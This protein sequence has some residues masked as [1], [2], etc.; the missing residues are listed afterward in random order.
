MAAPDA[1]GSMLDAALVYAARGW[2]V[3]P[4]HTIEGGACSCGESSCARAGKH[5]RTRNGLHNA[6]TEEAAIRRWWGTWS[7]ANIGIA[8]GSQS[9]FVVLDI[10]SGGEDRLVELQG[11]HGRL[12]EAPSQT[13]GSGGRHLLFAVPEG[14]LRNSNSKV[15]RKIDVRAD[16][17]YIVAPPSVHVS[18]T[19][20]AW[21]LAP[22]EAQLPAMPEWLLARARPEVR[23]VVN[24]SAPI[25]SDVTTRARR[26]LAAMPP[27]VSG[28]N[29]HGAL[30]D[31]ACA[32][33]RGF[34]LSAADAL[35]L[36]AGDYNPRC[37]PPWTRK[38]L[39]HKIADAERAS[40]RPFGY[41][42]DAPKP[43][44]AR[45]PRRAEGPA[46][47]P[48]PDEDTEREAIAAE[49]AV[50]LEV[51]ARVRIAA[52]E[53]TPPDE[54]P[55]IRL[56][57][58][59]HV[60]VNQAVAALSG[61]AGLYARDGVLVVVVHP[62]SEAP[63]VR[64]L[65]LATM[66]ERLT[67]AA[68]FERLREGEWD[69][70]LPPDAVALAALARGH[71]PGYRRLV[72]V[73]EAPSLRPDGSV[74]DVPGYDAA[75]GYLFAPTITFPRV[76][77]EPTPEEVRGALSALQEVFAD[78]PY[79]GRADA[80]AVLAA[81][82]TVLARP[83]IEGAVP[84][85]LFDATTPGSG[86]TLQADI[87]SLL[88]T[89]RT[90]AK[91]AYPVDNDDE[92][93]KILGGCALEGAQLVNFD[94]IAGAFGGAP[95]DKV[96]TADDMVKLRILGTSNTPAVRW[97]AVVM[98][99]GNNIAYRGDTHRRVLIPRLEPKTENPEERADFRYPDLRG[100]VRAERGRLVCAA[101]TILRAWVC[102]GRPRSGCKVWGSFEA[103]S[104]LIPPALVW[105]GAAD[106]MAC[107]PVADPDAR[108]EERVAMR[109]TLEAIE[110]LQGSI[111][112]TARGI[113]DLLYPAAFLRG[114]A[115]PDAFGDAREAIEMLTRTPA[116]RRPDTT[117]LG[118]ALRRWRRRPLAGRRLDMVGETRDKVARW[119]VCT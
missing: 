98:G 31:A 87:V 104:T 18:G 110:Q 86:K 94:N 67:A 79:R 43:E 80:A 107:R 70:C 57:A 14:G 88:A 35:A 30:W 52:V 6:T 117:R 1:H 11:V 8:T 24:T 114:E 45:A 62:P 16:G 112:I 72:G 84:A 58:E 17:G 74:F 55:R 15:A 4:L 99:T 102:A 73:L 115:P 82:F 65:A 42:R 49:P 25:P 7:T 118:F 53:A 66:R 85:F 29:G 23:P 106:P 50:G 10:D 105:A 56:G 92:V 54:R 96:L 3:F 77:A 60:N 2:A 90:T 21:T 95:I 28:Q 59:L 63:M 64:V 12:P 34:G 111:G 101:L 38:E 93:E 69:R 33:V 20:Y 46:E 32:M 103:W 78:F 81:V 41:L 75:T 89:G 40:D 48:A 61:D 5:P 116:G 76:P 22:D 36:L 97:R 27:A 100:Y 68:R 108:D 26:Y 44:L 71:W 47:T 13:T 19:R 113:V 51:S 119:M 37:L 91:M 9:G 109:A 39:E 83:A